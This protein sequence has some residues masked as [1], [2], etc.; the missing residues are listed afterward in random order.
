MSGPAKGIAAAGEPVGMMFR[1]L[2]N[3]L[4]SL[5]LEKGARQKL[6][7]KRARRRPPVGP[8]PPEHRVEPE[9]TPGRREL[10]DN[11]MKVRRD[12]ARI[13]DESDIKKEQYAEAIEKLAGSENQSG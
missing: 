4:L 1:L 7:R 10:I 2:S 12:T 9:M 13:L 6:A 11:A 8:A 3:A 5:V